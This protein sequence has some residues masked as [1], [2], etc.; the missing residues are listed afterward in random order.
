MRGQR[1]NFTKKL[2]VAVKFRLASVRAQQQG[3]Q[4]KPGVVA[5]ECG[6]SNKFMTR[7]RHELMVHGR[8]LPPSKVPGGVGVQRG[9]GARTL[10][11]FDRFVLLQL[12]MEEP[13]RSLSSYVHWLREYTDKTVSKSTVSCFFL[14]TF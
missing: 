6:V 3:K 12:R 14:T 7:I 2:E 10:D 13:S 11:R 9:A 5:R 1:Y 8:V 4:V